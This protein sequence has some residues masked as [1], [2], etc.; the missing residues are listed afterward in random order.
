MYAE[1]PKDLAGADIVQSFNND[2]KNKAKVRY[3]VELREAATL[4]ILV[5]TRM[6][7]P[8][9][10]TKG[11]GTLTRTS[12]ECSVDIGFD[13]AVYAMNVDAGTYAFGSQQDN[14]FYAIAARKGQIKELK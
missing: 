1:I 3:E 2:K 11:K 12:L 10:M 14:S 7:G 8:P 4:F 5:D 9:R 6:D 13:F